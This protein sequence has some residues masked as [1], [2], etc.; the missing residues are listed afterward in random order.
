M[1]PTFFA[2]VVTA[3]CVQQAVSLPFEKSAIDGTCNIYLSTYF[4][5]WI[6]LDTTIHNC[7]LTVEHLENT[8]H[9][10][11]LV[12]K[13]FEDADMASLVHP[14]S[15]EIAAREPTDCPNPYNNSTNEVAI[16]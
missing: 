5:Y 4:L 13:A 16:S 1:A 12:D 8:F 9:T 7:A 14:R 11:A 10:E 2:F 6:S 3:L 15:L